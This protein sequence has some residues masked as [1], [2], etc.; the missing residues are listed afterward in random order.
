MRS[1][2]ASE[3]DTSVEHTTMAD[4]E[5]YLDDLAEWDRARSEAAAN[6]KAEADADAD[7][8]TRIPKHEQDEDLW[9]DYEAV[10][11]HRIPGRD[12]VTRT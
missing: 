5:P 8:E 11:N 6:D 4:Y 12:P 3:P 10:W 9:R 2:T 7:T 1:Q